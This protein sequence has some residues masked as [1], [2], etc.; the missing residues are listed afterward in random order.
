M[1]KI[2]ALLTAILLLSTLLVSCMDQPDNTTLRIG[3]MSGPTGMGMAK[4]MN[5]E[6]QNENS[7]YDFSVYSAPT[8]ATADLANG[9]LDMLCLPT[10]TAATLANQKDDYISV[11]SINC[12]GSLYLITDANTII[13]S[14]SDLEGKTIYASVPNS[15]TGSII[16]YILEENDVEAEIVFEADH[17][18]LVAKIASGDT[19]IAVLPEPKVTAALI[20]NNTYSV[21]LNLSVEWDKVSDDPLAMGCIVVKNDFLRDHKSVV[22]KFLDDYKASIEYIG[23]GEN[24]DSAAQMIVDAGVL[25]ALPVAKKALKNLYGSIE[26]IDGAE[27]K[28]ALVGFYN[29][30][31]L[32]LPDDSFYYDE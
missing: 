1:K 31:D 28:N 4:L 19:S 15:T 22:D 2:I 7:K 29:A 26:Y 11:L 18:A 24:L 3:V 14:V 32:A 27:M 30:I 21:D 6:A 8:N 23:D 25:P 17:D 20:Q 5:D 10:N 16:N 13:T 9:T 12:L